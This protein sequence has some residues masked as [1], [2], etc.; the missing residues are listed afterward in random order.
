MASKRQKR[1]PIA[2]SLACVCVLGLDLGACGG[3][4]PAP[5]APALASRSAPAATPPPPDLSPVPE[6]ASLVASARLAKPSASLATVHA[7]SK[8]PMPEAEQVTELVANQ[9]LGPVVDLDKPIDVAIAVW[10]AARECRRPSAPSPP[11]SG[12]P[13][14]C[15]RCCRSDSSWFP[16]PTAPRS[17]K[18]RANR[19]RSS[20]PTRT[21]PRTARRKGSERV[22]SRPRTARRPYD[23]CAGPTRRRWP[24]SDRGSRG[25][26]REYRC[27]RTCTWTFA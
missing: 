14:W 20:R 21:T 4:P 24:S 25:P 1:A 16:R 12:T 17:F 2:G 9:Q 18:R 8:L 15:A 5:Q 11:R 10:A 23:S 3:S 19:R 27:R 22:S 7:W 6:P 13:R 26:R